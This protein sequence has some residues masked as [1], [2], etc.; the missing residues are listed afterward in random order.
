VLD[1]GA[2]APEPVAHAV[3]LLDVAY[4]DAHDVDAEPRADADRR[5]DDAGGASPR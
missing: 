2:V 5:R 1:A 3:R 4:A